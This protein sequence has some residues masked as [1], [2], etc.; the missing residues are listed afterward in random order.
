MPYLARYK[1]SI[2]LLRFMK[3]RTL[4]TIAI[5]FT[6]ASAAGVILEV[7]LLETYAQLS[8]N[9][10]K[11]SDRY[12]QLNITGSIQLGPTISES[13]RSQIHT[14]LS[15]AVTIA[16]QAVGQNSSVSGANLR[17]VNGFLVYAVNVVG[18]NATH[19]RLLVDPGDG[20]VLS[21][22]SLGTGSMMM[23]R[24]LTGGQCHGRGF[25]DIGYGHGKRNFGN[26]FFS[27]SQ[28]LGIVRSTL[29]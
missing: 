21:T 28:A 4:L 1:Y 13:I 26:G 6:L 29:T 25:G 9:S 27:H 10:T 12:G 8:N 18:N 16:Q 11:A 5:F 7:T 20:K 2:G 3:N 23:D 24:G 14:S 22:Q 17:A 19:Y 15:Q